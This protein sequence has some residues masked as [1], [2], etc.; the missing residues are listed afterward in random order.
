MTLAIL[1]AHCGDPLTQDGVDTGTP[2]AYDPARSSRERSEGGDPSRDA[3]VLF[4]CAA[5]GL[6]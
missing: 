6:P 2:A 4:E 3:L 5:M 1:N